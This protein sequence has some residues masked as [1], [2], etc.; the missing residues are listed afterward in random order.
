MTIPTQQVRSL[1]ALR[2][3][4][5]AA[6]PPR[7][8]HR[9]AGLRATHT[10]CNRQVDRSLYPSRHKGFTLIEVMIVV[11]VIAIL[12]GIAWPSYQKHVMRAHR[13]AVQQFMLDIVNREEQYMLDARSYATGVNALT[14]LNMT[15]PTNVSPH[16]TISVAAVAGPPV[17]YTVTATA[18]GTQSADGNL[19]LDS[20]GAKTPSGK[21]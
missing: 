1:P 15:V 8:G 19:T 4:Q 12:A 5:F 2:Q 14:T 11:G 18:T 21:W 6:V 7:S 10:S 17:G 3:A 9:S 13:S 16:Y 20:T